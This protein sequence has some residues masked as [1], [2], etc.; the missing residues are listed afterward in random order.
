MSEN[1]DVPRRSVRKAIVSVAKTAK[2]SAKAVLVTGR[3]LPKPVEIEP[4]PTESPTLR[5]LRKERRRLIDE[6]KHQ[7]MLGQDHPTTKVC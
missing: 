6:L 5:S 2:K 1:G 3:T 7:E 4:R